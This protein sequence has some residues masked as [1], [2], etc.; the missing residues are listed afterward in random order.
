MFSIADHFTSIGLILAILS[1]LLDDALEL[2][3]VF[4]EVLHVVLHFLNHLCQEGWT[5]AE[6]SLVLEVSEA[7]DSRDVIHLSQKAVPLAKNYIVLLITLVGLLDLRECLATLVAL[8][9]TCNLLITGSNFLSREIQL[10]LQL[11]LCL[12]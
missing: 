11:V 4:L 7:Q 5:T 6:V 12:G 1:Q 9:K 2:T 10:L 3:V 8:V